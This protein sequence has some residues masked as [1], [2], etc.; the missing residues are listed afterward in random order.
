MNAPDS[1]VVEHHDV[2][3]VGSGFAGIGMAS[4]LRERGYTD[5][6]IV[7]RAD[8]VGGTW[9]D[10]R[11]PGAA[12]DVPSH[13]YSFS[14]RPNPNWSRVFSPQRE[15]FGY[16]RDTVVERGLEDHLR[17][18]EELLSAR[19]D[20]GNEIWHVKTSR[21]AYTGRILVTATGH[22]SD[23]K[24]PNIAGLQDFAGSLFHSATWD[25]DTDLSG[26]RVGIIGTGASAIQIIPEVAAVAKNLVVFQRS[27]P[28]VTP[29]HDRA[30][31]DAEKRSFERVPQLIEELRS[32]LFWNNEARFVERLAVP[33][34]L[35][36]TARVALDHLASQ[37]S[38]P[39]LRAKLTPNYEI[40][41]KRIL[42]SNDYYPAL[43][44]ENVRVETVG[45]ERVD[46]HDVVLADGARTEL[47][48]II[49]ATGFEASDLPISYRITGRDEVLLADQWRT[50]MQA[51]ATTT[52]H[53]FPNMFVMNGPNSGLGHNSIIYIIEAQIDYILGALHHMGKTGTSVLEVTREAEEEY[54]SDLDARSQGTVWLTGGCHN[55]YVDERNGRLTTVWPDFAHAFRDENSIFSPEGYVEQA[56]SDRDLVGAALAR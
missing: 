14:F 55:W 34:L 25:E 46:G 39:E 26:L 43:A 1:T 18:G 28:Y 23:P 48:V 35:A 30:Y 5:F 10:N 49:S 38:D 27:A 32:E 37:V 4:Q 13:L 17:L 29:R 56:E 20:E 31:S 7:E 41:C 11:Y 52:V 8:D 2:I 6:V 24:L 9:R 21:A 33:A 22:L 12:C 42:K 51:Y 45:I 40:G 16:L 44:R 36:D 50:G 19:W 53:N 47:D 3:I 54:A 15:I